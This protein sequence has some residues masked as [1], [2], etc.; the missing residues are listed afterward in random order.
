MTTKKTKT[1]QT[2]RKVTTGTCQ[3]KGVREEKKKKKKKKTVI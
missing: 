3:E 2:R 1:P